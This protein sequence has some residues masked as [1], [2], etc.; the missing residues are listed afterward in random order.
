M[1][2]ADLNTNFLAAMLSLNVPDN[3][4]R[5][6]YARKNLYKEHDLCCGHPMRTWMDTTTHDG[7]P[8]EDR[9]YNSRWVECPHDAKIT[10]AGVLRD[11]ARPENMVL[12]AWI[13]GAGPLTI[14]DITAPQGDRS[15]KHRY[16]FTL[17]DMG[18]TFFASP[19]RLLHTVFSK[20]NDE[21]LQ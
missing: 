6:P 7:Y 4:E 1:N 5:C 20:R 14:W 21:D 10:P 8:T 16:L 18:T 2:I 17:G 9:P 19:A 3:C 15:G 12:Q 13:N 11:L